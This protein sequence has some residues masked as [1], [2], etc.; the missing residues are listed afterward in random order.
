MEEAGRWSGKTPARSC[1]L[2]RKS[3]RYGAGQIERKNI[4]ERHSP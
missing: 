1:S 3:E 4:G 2:G